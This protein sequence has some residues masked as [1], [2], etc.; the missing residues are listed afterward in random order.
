MIKMLKKIKLSDWLSATA[1]ALA[2]IVFVRDCSQNKK[3]EE[4]G[5]VSNAL[6][7]RPLLQVLGTPQIYS[8]EIQTDRVAIPNFSAAPESTDSIQ[9]IAAS[10]RIYA[11]LLFVNA[12]NAIA[13]VYAFIWA[14]TS[15]GSATIRAILQ[16]RKLRE[17][18]FV[19]FTDTDYFGIKDIRPGDTCDFRIAHDVRFVTKQKF[20]MHFLLL[21]RNEA[22][23]LFDTYYWARFTTVPILWKTEFAINDGKLAYRVGVDRKQFREFLTLCDHNTSWRV[24][25]K[26][27]AEDILSFFTRH[28]KKDGH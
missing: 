7:F 19:A 12:G 22:G 10:L 1:I 9:D 27:D 17:Q 11:R 3:I 26:A 28:S 14:D 20:T 16:D 21:Y 24:Y 25:S 6:Q 4:L 13:N 15:S 8:Y 18:S 2:I 23:G 5:Y